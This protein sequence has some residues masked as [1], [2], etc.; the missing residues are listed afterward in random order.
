MRVLMTEAA[1]ALAQRYRPV[2]VAEVN[3]RALGELPYTLLMHL[4]GVESPITV[5][6]LYAADPRSAAASYAAQLRQLH[7]AGLLH[8]ENT[9]QGYTFTDAGLAHAE[10]LIAAACAALDAPGWPLADETLLTTLTD[11][12]DAILAELDEAE[13]PLP[14]ERT[15]FLN[16]REWLPAG[17]GPVAFT[18]AVLVKLLAYHT[19]CEI[20]AWR[21][22]DLP[23]VA[24][25]ILGRFDAS[26]PGH[27]T[28]ALTI[29]Q[30][31]TDLH[32]SGYTPLEIRAAVEG[33][34][35]RRLVSEYPVDPA[36]L[37]LTIDGASLLS[38]VA[39][40]ADK[41]FERPIHAVLDAAE[42]RTL[43]RDL[44]KL[45]DALPTPER[46]HA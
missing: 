17:Y 6:A 10:G 28:T 12:V 42:L 5:D 31:T 29:E 23:P 45:V 13:I 38:S 19:D 37:R 1:N 35:A 36:R 15:N 26:A 11:L 18:H 46:D 40:T 24:P 7:R 25:L 9:A 3:A 34:L 2:L 41:H 22:L 4:R 44:R 27:T 39:A 32:D 21:A 8:T 20:A 14:R 43:R 33:L 16:T 30:L